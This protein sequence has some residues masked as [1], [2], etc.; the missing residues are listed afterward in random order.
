MLTLSSNLTFFNKKLEK[1]FIIQFWISA[2]NLQFCILNSL[3]HKVFVK[4]IKFSFFH[5]FPS[6]NLEKVIGSRQLFK[7][8][9]SERWKAEILK[10]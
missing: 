4:F 3:A 2:M 8:A 7:S 9:F 1:V 6:Y 5:V 10:I